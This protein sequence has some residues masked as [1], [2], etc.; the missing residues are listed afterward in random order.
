MITSSLLAILAIWKI[1]RQPLWLALAIMSP[2]VALELV[3]LGANLLKIANGGAVP[4]VIAAAFVLIMWT[5]VRGSALLTDRTRNTGSMN[6]LL[7]LIA[8]SPPHRIRG[9]AVFLTADPTA[10]PTALMHNLKHNQVLHE[11][12]I[13]LTVKFSG[14]PRASDAERIQVTSL[15]GDVHLV[16]LVFGFMETPNVARALALARDRG[17]LKFDIMTTS[18]FLSR[19]ALVPTRKSAMP[20]WQ[21]LLFVFLARNG[22]DATEFFHIPTSRVVELGAQVTV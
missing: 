15:R 6:G 2:F 7:E 17:L 14:L 11:N 18:F 22:T 3:F 13:L 4:L 9:T 19:R 10:A 8:L 20:F 12:V 1:W 21:D 5:W 16:T